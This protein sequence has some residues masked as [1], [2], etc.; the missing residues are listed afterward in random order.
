MQLWILKAV[1]GVSSVFSI[2]H[3]VD[4]GGERKEHISE[5]LLT[6]RSG[7]TPRFKLCQDECDRHC[8]TRRTMDITKCERVPPFKFH[9]LAYSS[10]LAFLTCSLVS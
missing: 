5:V 3:F 8:W 10:P 1:L 7:I 6:D 2:S 4:S 9:L